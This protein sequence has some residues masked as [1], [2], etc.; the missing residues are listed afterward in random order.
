MRRFSNGLKTALL[1][2]LL[3]A[4]VLTAGYW[5][6][7][8]P[9]LVVATVLAVLMNGFAYFH[10]DRIALRAMGARE[11]RPWEAPELHATVREL[12][13][14]AGQ[15]MPRVY[16]SPLAQPNAFATGRN[17]QNAAVCVT[18]G[19]LSLLTPRELRAVLGHEMSHVANR[20]ILISTV[21]AGLASII[22][23]V[24]NLAFFFPLSTDDEDAPNPVAALLMLLIAPMA[25][26]LI[27]L[28]V[29]RSREYQA[30]LDGARI[31]G[32]PLALASALQKIE[33]GAQLR[34]LSPDHGAVAQAHLMTAN[35][36]AGSGVAAL[37][38][39][40]P[41]TQDRVRRL[42]ELAGT[43]LQQAGPPL[44]RVNLS[45]MLR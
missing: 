16:L 23:S 10:S 12:A 8:G 44:Q 18:E 37:F 36:L 38:R 33:H 39:T 3:S 42:R 26:G 2:G 9:G 20:D 7:G 28:A 29:S 41:S 13:A 43:L 22:T 24:A 31:T 14:A 40:H 19:L 5:L 34:P 35:P 45:R 30:D 11:L 27:Q 1:L 25:A 6:G 4:L 32:D 15:P 21:A 17:P